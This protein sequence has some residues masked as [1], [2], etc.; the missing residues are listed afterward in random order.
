MEVAKVRYPQQYLMD[1]VGFASE[2]PTRL[3]RDF[4]S[5]E[6]LRGL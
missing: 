5:S 2:N 4:L 1:L 3:P 6:I